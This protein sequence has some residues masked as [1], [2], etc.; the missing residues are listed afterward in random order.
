MIFSRTCST[1][2]SQKRVVLLE[3]WKDF[4]RQYGGQADIDKVQAMM[5]IVSRKQRKVDEQG[6]NLEECKSKVC[7]KACVSVRILL[8]TTRALLPNQ[9]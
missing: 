5:P 3:G 2:P 8:I 9:L 1:S 4:E 7:V 6:D